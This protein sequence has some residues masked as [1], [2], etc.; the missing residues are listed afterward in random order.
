VTP[1]IEM[2]PS[3]GA[4]LA[5]LTGGLQA[6]AREMIPNGNAPQWGREGRL[7]YADLNSDFE[8]QGRDGVA[9]FNVQDAAGFQG[10]YK[11]NLFAFEMV[12]RAGF[13]VPLMGRRHGWGYLG[14][15]SVTADATQGHLRGEWGRVATGET[16]E[17]LDSAIVSG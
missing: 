2:R 14:P 5:G 7:T 8:T 15:D 16:A 12:R 10:V 4:P 17:S 3:S 1:A 6:V 13:Q 11:C 9:R